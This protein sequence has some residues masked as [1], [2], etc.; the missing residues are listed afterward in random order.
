MGAKLFRL[1][2]PRGFSILLAGLIYFNLPSPAF[3]NEILLKL[4]KGDLTIA[5]Q[6]LYFD[7]ENYVVKTD[8]LGRV[9]VNADRFSCIGGVCPKSPTAK[10]LLT[11]NTLIR[12]RGSKTIGSRLVPAMIRDY[13]ANI[14]ATVQSSGNEEGS[15]IF[16]LIGKNGAKLVTID[17]QRHGSQTAFP[18]LASGEADIG[19]ADRSITDE[20]IGSL[21]KAGFPQMNRPGHEH[22]VGLDSMV[23]I[24]SSKNSIQSLSL[25]ELSR[26]FSG[27]TQ[28]WSEFDQ[29]PAKINVY[30]A[31]EKTGDF[32]TFWSFVLKPFSRSLSPYADTSKSHTELAEAVENDPAGIGFVSLSLLGSAKPLT[33]KDTC[34]LNHEPS[35]F[36]VKSGEF[37]LARN[38]YFYTTKLTKKHADG[39][40]KY[41]IS[42]AAS[43]ALKEV[44]FTDNSIITQLFDRFRDRV[45]VSLNAS[46]ED[47]DLD[48]MR[49][50][51]RLLGP[52]KRLSATMRFETL[53][54]Q[55]DSESIQQLPDIARYLKGEDLTK[56]KIIIAGYSDSTG[57]FE[58]NRGLAL[59]RAETVRD[60][61]LIIAGDELRSENIEI[62]AFAELFPVGCNDTEAGR[63]KNRRVEIWLAPLNHSRPVILSKQP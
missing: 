25:E 42:S 7:G 40:V 24:V 35:I 52:G 28:D 27:E 37:P 56:E 30:S 61:L 58:F 8:A 14:G 20:E 55:L 4:D 53:S 47:F 3:S 38:L 45:Y 39:F 43:G 19:T 17:L 10:T 23:I 59:K 41:A 54:S 49:Q 12:I 36:G 1:R 44:G 57:A 18:A 51:M 13:A 6:L 11:D 46:R 50:L 34:G 16:D 22:V 62:Q 31:N 26:I 32:R 2:I 29:S 5:G 9:R 15:V 48:L 63:E 33:I 21:A 60:A